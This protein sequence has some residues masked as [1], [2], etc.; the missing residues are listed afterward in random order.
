VI[1]DVAGAGAG[2]EALGGCCWRS[3]IGAMRHET[4]FTRL[5]RT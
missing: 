2:L 4:Q 3:E 5:F 1:L